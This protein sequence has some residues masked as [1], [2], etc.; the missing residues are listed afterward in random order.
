MRTF[1][2]FLLAAVLTFLTVV[3]AQHP[4]GPA[5]RAGAP[6]TEV[7]PDLAGIHKWDDSNGDSWDPFWADDGELYTFN[8]DGRGFGTAQR[9]LAFH[10]LSGTSIPALAGSLVNPM[11]EYGKANQKEGDNATWKACGQECI[12]SVFYAFVSRNVYGK[13]S[14]DPEMRQTAFNSSLIKS[15]AR[16]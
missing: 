3:H 5:G 2:H 13:E 9:N 7:F 16:G 1:F 12:D 15:T 10:K 14:G 4:E 6:I 8:C 11:D